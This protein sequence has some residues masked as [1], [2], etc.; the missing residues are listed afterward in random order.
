[1]DRDRRPPLGDRTQYLFE[2]VHL[3]HGPD[4]GVHGTAS[5]SAAAAKVQ[6]KILL[7][8]GRHAGRNILKIGGII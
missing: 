8:T 1:M 6:A 2:A 7:N 3:Y 5:G 4:R